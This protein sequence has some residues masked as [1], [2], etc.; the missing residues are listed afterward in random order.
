MRLARVSTCLRKMGRE[1]KCEGFAGFGFGVVCLWEPRLLPEPETFSLR[2]EN[3]AT[4]RCSLVCATFEDPEG[5]G[6]VERRPNPYS[7]R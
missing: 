5:I 4:G 7:I 3:E 6:A 2:E 1:A